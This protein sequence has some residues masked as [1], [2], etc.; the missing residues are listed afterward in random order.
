MS[1]MSMQVSE[2]DSQAKPAARVIVSRIGE[3]EILDANLVTFPRGVL[4][5]EG[6]SDFAVV[7]LPQPGMERFKLLQST[8]DPD[9]GFIVTEAASAAAAIDPVD[10]KDAYKQCDIRPSDAL[11][12]LIV[13]IRKEGDSV[14]MSANLR[15]P[16]IID[17]QRRIGRQH[18]MSNGRY[19]I[20]F[21]L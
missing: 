10:L 21:V 13:S 9:L 16:I 11:T 2:D 15:A 17:M 20:R 19:P 18:V 12:L 5:F 7:N 8:E 14:E 6:R 3:V 4:G 1:A